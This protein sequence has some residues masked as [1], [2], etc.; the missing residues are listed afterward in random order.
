LRQDYSQFVGRG[1]EVV[2]VAPED[3]V[4]LASYWEQEQLPF[5]GLAD[6]DHQ[7]AALYRQ[8]V[9]L[10]TLGRMPALLIVDKEGQ[11]RFQRFGNAMSDI[12]PNDEVLKLLDRL[13]H[14]PMAAPNAMLA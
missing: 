9:S 7:V 11:L 4:T 3:R 13:N 1:T 6:P 2:V 5:V 8:E 10:L 14:E 12:V